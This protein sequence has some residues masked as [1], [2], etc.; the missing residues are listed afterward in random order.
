[1]H[2]ILSIGIFGCMLMVHANFGVAHARY[3]V[4]RIAGSEI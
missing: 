2:A 1:M 4:I 3:H